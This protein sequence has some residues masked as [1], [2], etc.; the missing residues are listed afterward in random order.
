MFANV[1]FCFSVLHADAT[2]FNFSSIRWPLGGM[3]VARFKG[4]TNLLFL[5]SWIIQLLQ[6][7]LQIPPHAQSVLPT[8]V[9]DGGQKSAFL[10]S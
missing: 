5:P 6:I 4:K 3:Q 8:L 10:H 2:V 7:E 1:Y 9:S